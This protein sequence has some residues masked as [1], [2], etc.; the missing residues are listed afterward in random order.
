MAPGVGPTIAAFIIT[1]AVAA[2]GGLTAKRLSD[3]L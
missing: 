3:A 1:F 2:V